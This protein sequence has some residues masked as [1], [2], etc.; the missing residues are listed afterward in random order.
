MT[1]LDGFLK[2]MESRIKLVLGEYY[3]VQDPHWNKGKPFIARY[4]GAG[5]FGSHAFC[6]EDTEMCGRSRCAISDNINLGADT[7]IK[8]IP[9]NEIVR[10]KYGK[11]KLPSPSLKP[12]PKIAKLMDKLNP[13]WQTHPTTHYRFK[14]KEIRRK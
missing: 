13:G 5:L 4:H 8:H 12:D 1:H 10:Y 9:K 6:V 2:T 3:S 7:H 14:R 11:V